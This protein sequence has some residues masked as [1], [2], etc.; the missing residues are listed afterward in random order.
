MRMQA[1][2]DQSK[3]S[4]LGTQ[5]ASPWHLAQPIHLPSKPVRREDS[6][7][8]AHS[9]NDPGAYCSSSRP[10]T[11]PA[12][13]RA[14]KDGVRSAG[15]MDAGRNGDIQQGKTGQLRIF[16]GLRQAVATGFG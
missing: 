12:A 5:L 15:L 10:D 11:T 13:A 14:G 9:M 16:R 7:A 2:I 3:L 4:I 6:T 8:A 1:A